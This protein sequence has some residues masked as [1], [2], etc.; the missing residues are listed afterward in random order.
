MMTASHPSA[1]TGPQTMQRNSEE[2]QY[3]Q[4][5]PGNTSLGLF[6]SGPDQNVSRDMRI[7]SNDMTNSQPGVNFDQNL[8]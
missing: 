2:Q 8:V 4:L 1:G 5:I 6:G 7:Q 3:E